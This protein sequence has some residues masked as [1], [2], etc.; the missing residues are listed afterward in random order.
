MI[1]NWRGVTEEKDFPFEGCSNVQVPFTSV[2]VEQMGARL[3]KGIFGGDLWSKLEYVEKQVESG[4]LDETNLWWNWE[5]REVVKLKAAVRD[6]VHDMLVTGISIPIPSYH[7]ETQMLHSFKEWA[8]ELDQPLQLLIQQ[9]IEEILSEPSAW[10]ADQKTKPEVVKQSKPGIYEL[11]EDGKIIFSLDLDKMRLRA[12]I[13]RREVVFDGARINYVSLEDLIVVNTDRDI[14]KLPF[15]GV[16]LFYSMADYRQGLQD[17]FFIDYGEEETKRILAHSDNKQGTAI[18]QPI[19]DLQDSEEGTDSRDLSSDTPSHRMIECYRWEG[20]WYWDQEHDEY[21]NMLAPATQICAWVDPDSRMLLKVARLE[22]L[23]KDGKRSGVKF[24]FMEEPGRFFPMGLAE[25]VRHIQYVLNAISNQRVDAGLISNVPWGFYKP[26]AGMKGTIRMEP[27]VFHP[28][29]GGSDSII[30]PRNNW[31]PTFGVQEEMLQR[32]YGME[33]AGLSEAA[34]GHPTSKR[35]SATE[36]MTVAA[37]LDLRTED[38][39][40][41]LLESLKELLTRVLGLYQ[42]FG[43][44]ERIFRVG[45][46]G[47]VQITKRFER[48]RLQGKILLTMCGNVSLINEQVRRETAMNMFALLMNPILSQ[49]QIVAPDTTYQAIKLIAKLSNYEDVPLH[50]PKTPAMSDAPDVEEKQMFSGQKPTGPTMG[51]NS[52]EHYQHHAMTMAD[53]KLMESWSPIARQLLEQ[54]MQATLQM[55]DAQQIMAQQQAAMAVQAAQQMN[56]LGVRPGQPGGQKAG[57]NAG[58][59]TEAEGVGGQGSLNGATAAGSRAGQS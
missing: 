34:V 28:F 8:F 31:N 3:L 58:P 18:Q 5:L 4:Q 37:A 15:F 20:W 12:D 30:M 22:D 56:E 35:Q 33:Q 16:R 29:A 57:E 10:G 50:K 32:H 2:V 54:H 45:G 55:R 9:G 47:G 36:F 41:R 23:N 25:W 39:L 38:V 53:S 24:G 27:G 48:D 14:D 52:D 6:I 40:E 1:A 13:W 43:P 17:G 59:G 51:E 19:T 26:G 49:M 46:E 11:T 7:H 21:E 44:Q 42:Q